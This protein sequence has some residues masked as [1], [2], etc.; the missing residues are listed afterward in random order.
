[1]CE[2]LGPSDIWQPHPVFTDKQTCEANNRCSEG[3]VCLRWNSPTP[4]IVTLQARPLLNEPSLELNT[5]IFTAGS[6]GGNPVT[7]ALCNP[8]ELLVGV[9]LRSGAWIDG[10]SS[11]FCNTTEKILSGAPPR[12]IQTNWGGGGSPSTF[13]CPTG[14]ALKSYKVGSGSWMDNIS[15]QCAEI[16]S[17]SPSDESRTFG[18]GNPK[19]FRTC[20]P[21]QF[22]GG[23][24]GNAGSFMDSLRGQCRDVK[25]L[26]QSFR[27]PAIQLRC[28]SGDIAD[29]LQCANLYPSSS[30]CETKTKPQV[31][32]QRQYFFS[33]PCKQMLARQN[34]QITSQTDQDLAI[35]VCRQ[36]KTD[37][38]ATQEEKDWCA[39]INA[40]VPS[41]IEP[42]LRGVFQ[43]IDSTCMTK[44]L[45]PFGL[46]CPTTYTIC[47][48]RDFQTALQSS[49][50]G[51]FYIQNNCGQFQPPPNKDNNPAPPLPQPQPGP[52]PSPPKEAET[53]YRK[54]ALYVLGGILLLGGAAV[55]L[56]WMAKRGAQ[57]QQ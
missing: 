53:N 46:Q 16:S 56:M 20:E 52:K 51:K 1:M 54:I 14:A 8:D 32:S 24:S 44:G 23:L 47:T 33:A 38:N 21:G 34:R 18:G 26:Q 36:V 22:L 19:Q 57:Q 2:Y 39:C 43:C 45:L 7:P 6:S 10:I 5:P 9:R 11:V 31:C 17:D 42:T 40:D 48:N 41:D 3:G 13:F 29:P 27:D 30:T 15:F 50:V 55:L 28:C 12:E 4:S 37:S 35:S 25:I 49:E